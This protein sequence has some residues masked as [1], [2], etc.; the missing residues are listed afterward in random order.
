MAL[1]SN[2]A[3]QRRLG[4]TWHRLHLVGMHYVW[5][6]FAFT[7]Y[8]RLAGGREGATEDLSQVGAIGFTMCL[9]ALAIRTAAFWRSK[10]NVSVA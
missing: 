6:I 2:N 8:G 10:R 3:S 9:A 5:F 7:Y 1:T 4:R